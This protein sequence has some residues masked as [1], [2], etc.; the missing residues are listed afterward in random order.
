MAIT[1]SWT[2]FYDWN[3]DGS[4]S[5]TSMTV[6]A[7]GTFTDGEG[8][9]GTWVQ[10]AGMFMFTFNSSETTYAGNWASKSVTGISA[11]FNGLKGSFYMLQ[12]GVPTAFN[13][14]RVGDKKDA[15]GK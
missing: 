4:Y 14:E 5:K 3:S 6:N 8:H 10:T 13:A 2:L 1:G 11:T 15:I 9:S 12:A 7:G